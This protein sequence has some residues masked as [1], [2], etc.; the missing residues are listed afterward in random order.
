M[1]ATTTWTNLLTRLAVPMLAV[2][3][4]FAQSTYTP[5]QLSTNYEEASFASYSSTM[6]CGQPGRLACYGFFNGSKGISAGCLVPDSNILRSD[7]YSGLDFC[8]LPQPGDKFQLF[9][10]PNPLRPMEAT[11]YFTSDIHYYRDDTFNRDTQ[12]TFPYYLNQFAT[13][14]THWPATIGIPATDVINPPDAVVI[15]GDITTGGNPEMLGAFRWFWE[16]SLGNS[17]SLQY[18]IFPGLGNHDTTGA[19]DTQHA[20]RMYDYIGKYITGVNMDRSAYGLY[21]VDEGGN[22]GTHNYSWDWAGVHFVQLN[23]WAGDP[24]LTNT[25]W[26]SNG[27]EWLKEDL[28]INVG[29]SGRPVVLFQHYDLS[30]ISYPHLDNSQQPPVLKNENLTAKHGPTWSTDYWWGAADFE[31]FWNVIRDYHVVAMFTGHK[32]YASV[33]NIRD[34]SWPDVTPPGWP[35]LTDSKGNAVSFDEFR[36]GAGGSCE[37]RDANNNC[38]QGKAE[39]YAARITPHYLD[40]ASVAIHSID[41]AFPAQIGLDPKPEGD[42][43]ALFPGQST[44][45]HLRIDSRFVDVTSAFTIVNQEDGGV[46]LTN[47][48]TVPLS[49]PLAVQPQVSSDQVQT[50]L[51]QDF[52]DTCDRTMAHPYILVGTPGN[53]VQPQQTVYAGV[54]KDGS[55]GRNNLTFKVFQLQPWTPNATK[56]MVLNPSSITETS[57]SARKAVVSVWSPGAHSLTLSPQFPGGIPQW[58][59]ISN[60]TMASDTGSFEIDYSSDQSNYNGVLTATVTVTADNGATATLPLRWQLIPDLTFSPS[61]VDF[62][63]GNQQ[64]VLVTGPQNKDFKFTVKGVPEGYTVTPTSG[65]TPAVLTLT[66]NTAGLHNGVYHSNLNI[67]WDGSAFNLGSELE[68]TLPVTLKLTATAVIQTDPAGGNIIV[69]NTPYVAP[70]SFNWITGQQHQISPGPDMADQPNSLLRFASWSDGGAATHTITAPDHT[71]NFTAHLVRYYKVQTSVDAAGAPGVVNASPQPPANDGY[72][73]NGTSIQLQAVPG[74]DSVFTQFSGGLS[75]KQNPQSVI[76]NQPLSVTARFD[77]PSG[78]STVIDTNPSGHTLLVDGTPYR[79]PQTFRWPAT[80]SHVVTVSS[81]GAAPGSQW[82]FAAW[83]DGSLTNPRTLTGVAAGGNQSFTAGLKQQYQVAASAVPSTAGSFTGI[84]WLDSGSTTSI[85]AAPAAGFQFTGFTSPV[86]SSNPLVLTVNAPVNVVAGFSAVQAPRLYASA[87]ARTS[88]NPD[89]SIVPIAIHNGPSAGVAGDIQITGIANIRVMFGTGVVSVANDLLFPAPV[90]SLA[91]GQSSSPAA[92]TFL[93][94]AS[95]MRV[96]FDVQFTA[97]NG[98]YRGSTTLN[99]IR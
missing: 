41:L 13:S 45:C 24:G 97:N 90:G 42:Y 16:P 72:Y 98:A 44:A 9:P 67:L 73:Q 85:T 65:I 17:Y 60:S 10:I 50:I 23:T 53:V 12:V 96:Q 86:S 77:T 68:S 6:E 69:D 22:K 49:G 84:G 47:N 40:V 57:R 20:R 48:L 2:G 21:G 52:V 82:A 3:A 38:Y 27:L 87:G 15:G 54:L 71:T 11:F 62:V 28:A 81:D 51:N 61:S 74:F 83:G 76:V 34:F 36:N 7:S 64:Q 66:L 58:F 78:G 94:P 70:Q 55:I 92:I 37:Y 79:A 91:A 46:G 99:L 25:N 93:W 39:F 88:P 63:S 33:N 59:S 75:G 43:P 30:A 5:Y 4:A 14:G 31:G 56:L 35:S 29:S 18:P 26:Y 89:V 80:E 8:N 19:N 32:H 1:S 95:A